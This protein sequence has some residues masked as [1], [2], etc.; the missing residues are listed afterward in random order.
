VFGPD[1]SLIGLSGRIGEYPAQGSHPSPLSFFLLAPA[2][3]ALGSPN[4]HCFRIARTSPS[5]PRPAPERD[6]GVW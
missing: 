1:T 6:D 2:Y 4:S 5:A 3:W